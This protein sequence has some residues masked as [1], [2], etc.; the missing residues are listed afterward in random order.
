MKDGISIFELM[1]RDEPPF[2]K[3]NLEDEDALF[4]KTMWNNE[5]MGGGVFTK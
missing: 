4:K 1:F 2:E 3:Y 5:K